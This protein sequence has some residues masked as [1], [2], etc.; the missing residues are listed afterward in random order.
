MCCPRIGRNRSYC[1]CVFVPRKSRW[2]IKTALVYLAAALALGVVRAGQSAGLFPGSAAPLWLPQLHL[3]TVGWLTQLIFGVAFWLFP[4]VSR[5][6]ADWFEPA[7]WVAY[8]A[9]NLGLLLRLLAEPALLP[10][11]AQSWGLLGSAVLQWIASIC[12]VVYFWRR[13]RTK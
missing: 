11:G 5:K 2:L 8:V 10:P 4:S 7:I 12:F 6:G 3:L 13:M 9:L 1:C